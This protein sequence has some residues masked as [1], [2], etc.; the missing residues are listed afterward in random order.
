M[1]GGDIFKVMVE[2]DFADVPR[3]IA[4]G[5]KDNWNECTVLNEGY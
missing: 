5:S 2:D 3:Y 1:E 4:I